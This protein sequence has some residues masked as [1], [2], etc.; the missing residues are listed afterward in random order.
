MSQG[1]LQYCFD[2]IIVSAKQNGV[3]LALEHADWI[4]GFGSDDS[5]PRDCK[6]VGSSFHATPGSVIEVNLTAVAN[7][8]DGTML[9]IRP[10]WPFTKDKLVGVDLDLQFAPVVKGLAVL[11]LLLAAGAA[12]AL[13]SEKKKPRPSLADENHA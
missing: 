7:F 1:P 13:R 8:G 3:P 6:S 12:L 2:G 11:G 5:Y 9:V 4:Y 10:V